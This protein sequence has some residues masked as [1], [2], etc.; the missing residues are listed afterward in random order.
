MS[1]KQLTRS[2]MMLCHY[3]ERSVLFIVMLNVVILSAV[4]LSVVAPKEK[5]LDK[6]VFVRKIIKPV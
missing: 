6:K 1:L 3:D 4:M 2:I 5:L